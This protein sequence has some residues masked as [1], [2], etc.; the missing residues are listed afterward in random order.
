MAWTIARSRE[1][2][3][4]S[5]TPARQPRDERTSLGDVHTFSLLEHELAVGP[6]D[7]LIGAGT[8]AARLRSPRNYSA[9]E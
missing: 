5:K 6:T 3:A 8:A 4:S 7:K 9:Q 1:F 2:R